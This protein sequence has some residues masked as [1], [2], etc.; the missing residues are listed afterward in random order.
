MDVV[1]GRSGITCPAINNNGFPDFC[2]FY[3]VRAGFFFLFIL[4]GN[5]AIIKGIDR[6][7]KFCLYIQI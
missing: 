4:Y 6:I 2:L 5:T 7:L 1:E 3:P